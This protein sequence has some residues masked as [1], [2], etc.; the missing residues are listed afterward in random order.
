MIKL[1][2]LHL[3]I[4]IM[5]LMGAIKKSR[6]HKMTKHASTSNCVGKDG[7]GGFRGVPLPLPLPPLLCLLPSLCTPSLQSLLP[8]LP[9]LLWCCPPTATTTNDNNSKHGAPLKP[10]L[11]SL[12]PSTWGGERAC[13][14][15][16]SLP[17][18]AHRCRIPKEDWDHLGIGGSSS[19]PPPSSSPPSPCND[20]QCGG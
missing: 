16:L 19:L 2:V 12:L 3:V 8:L 10:P 15:P 13:H 6:R 5:P 18:L 1:R 20:G 17:P 11:P 9:L 14:G 7:S 4:L